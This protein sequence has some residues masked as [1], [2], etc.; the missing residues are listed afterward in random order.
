MYQIA[1]FLLLLLLSSLPVFFAR[2][3]FLRQKI[4]VSFP[5]FLLSLIAGVL[6]IFPAG[7]FQT[8]TAS[9]ASPQGLSFILYSIFVRTALSEETS[10]LL[11]QIP[12]LMIHRRL[13]EGPG[14]KGPFYS[15]PEASLPDREPRTFGIA[16]G[17]TAGLGFALVESAVYSLGSSFKVALLRAFTAAP[18]HGACG[19]RSGYAIVRFREQP[20]KALFRFFT[21]VLIHGVYNLT[22]INPVI[23]SAVGVL[24]AL[25]A[26]FSSIQELG[27]GE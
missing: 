11:T 5:W 16:S 27:I 24:I 6:S 7:L 21:A 13:A 9:L 18:L 2:W 1:V 12:L 17:L 26:L 15:L 20:G 19:A 4:P 14:G 23:P 3:W 10:R 25:A 22:L 8:W